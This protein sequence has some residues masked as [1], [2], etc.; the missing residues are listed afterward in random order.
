MSNNHIED[1]LVEVQGEGSGSG[2]LV[3]P[4]EGATVC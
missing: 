2:I 4:N 1:F 3:K